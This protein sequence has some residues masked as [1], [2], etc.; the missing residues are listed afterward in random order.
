ML[1]LLKVY[2][3][4]WSFITEYTLP[5]T[6]CKYHNNIIDKSNENMI[7]HGAHVIVS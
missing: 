7:K 2:R 6:S 3:Y 1:H 4:A 5:N